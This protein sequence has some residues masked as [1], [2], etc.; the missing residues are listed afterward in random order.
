MGLALFTASRL[1]APLHDAIGWLMPGTSRSNWAHQPPA[2]VRLRH[3]A[4]DSIASHAQLTRASGQNHSNSG[5]HRPLRALRILRVVEAGA[6]PASTGRMVISGR[7]ADVC[8]ELERLAA[9]EAAL[10]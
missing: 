1:F 7:M 8:A 10:H 9:G 5:T 3:G 2:D 6:A 4:H